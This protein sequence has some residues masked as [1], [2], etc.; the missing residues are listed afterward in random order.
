MMK[1]TKFAKAVHAALETLPYSQRT[2]AAELGIS[3][4]RLSKLLCSELTDSKSRP[5]PALLGK[6]FLTLEPHSRH[7]A[8]M[9]VASALADDRDR[10]GV[11]AN[12]V[13]VSIIRML[14]L[15]PALLM[16]MSLRQPLASGVR[17]MTSGS[18]LDCRVPRPF[19]WRIC[20]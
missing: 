9:V 4:S 17:R 19:W 11:P 7:H 14:S 18:P 13:S 20:R 6:L 10:A 3:E 5:T 12:R 2:L 1:S 16:L 15:S 8:S